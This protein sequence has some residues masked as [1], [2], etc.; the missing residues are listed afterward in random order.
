MQATALR[1]G[2]AGPGPWIA[3][4]LILAF[5]LVFLIV[6]V[7]TVSVTYVWA[8]MSA[9]VADSAIVRSSTRVTK[10]EP[11]S[12]R[13]SVPWP[14]EAKATTSPVRSEPQVS[15]PVRPSNTSNDVA[16][17]ASR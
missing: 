7:G 12:V 15:A 9:A 17:C 10:Y 11:P 16:A 2:N 8:S 3:F 4:G 6:P 13:P 14:P 1:P 5:L